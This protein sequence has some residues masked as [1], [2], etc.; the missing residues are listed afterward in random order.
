MHAEQPQ[1][2]QFGHQV[3]GEGAVLEPARDV[4][5]DP[6]GSEIAH[7][8]A[9]EALVGGQLIVNPEQIDIGRLARVAGWVT[10]RAA[11]R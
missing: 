8:V 2:A 4:R 9:D 11:A 3:S 7:R 5:L 6:V 10:G 1:F